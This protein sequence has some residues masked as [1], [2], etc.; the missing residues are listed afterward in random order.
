MRSVNLVFC[1]YSPTTKAFSLMLQNKEHHEAS[2][3]EA[4]FGS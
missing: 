3:G 4:S 1:E 2:Y